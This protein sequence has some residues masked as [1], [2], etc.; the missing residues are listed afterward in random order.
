MRYIAR[1]VTDRPQERG[2]Q[3]FQPDA[4]SAER[5]AVDYLRTSGCQVGDVV[6]VIEIRPVV[7]ASFRYDA[8]GAIQKTVV[9][10]GETK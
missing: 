6:E 3:K 10:S 8:D 5:F 9:E 7:V 4:V 1:L 2:V